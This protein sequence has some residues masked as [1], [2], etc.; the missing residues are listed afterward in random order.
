MMMQMFRTAATRG[1]GMKAAVGMRA[2]YSTAPMTAPEELN[3]KEKH[4]Y[5]KLAKELTPSK[6][7]VYRT[8]PEGVR[9][10]C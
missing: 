3:D 10:R 1:V 5:E 4:I 8:A 7:E 6:L 9:M 2:A